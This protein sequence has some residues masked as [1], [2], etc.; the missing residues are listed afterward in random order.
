MTLITHLDH[1]VAGYPVFEEDQILT[2]NHL[3]RL[4][5][6][7]EYQTRLTRAKLLGV[8]IVHGLRASLAGEN[9]ETIILS[10][11]CGITTDGD[12]VL[13]NERLTFGAYTVHDVSADNYAPF[14]SRDRPIEAWRLV[15]D[16]ERERGAEPLSLFTTRTGQA[17]AELVAVLFLENIHEGPSL[18]SGTDCDTRGKIASSHLRVLLLHQREIDRFHAAAPAGLFANPGEMEIA[19]PA[20][21]PNLTA[22]NDLAQVYRKAA[23][24]IRSALV[25]KLQALTSAD[26]LVEN[27]LFQGLFKTNPGADWAENLARLNRIWSKADN[28]IQYYYD[29][30]K[31]LAETYNTIAALLFHH[32]DLPAPDLRTFPKHLVLG[33]ISPD[34]PAHEHRTPF[35][36]SPINSLS[37][38]RLEQ[39][40][41]LIRKLDTLIRTFEVREVETGL[42]AITP[43]L[44]EDA[45]LEDRAIP[46]Y[47]AVNADNPIHLAW[48]QRRTQQG[49]ASRTPGYRSGEYRARG[50]PR[51]PLAFSLSRFP[52]FRIEGYLGRRAR[53]VVKEIND[54]ITA[55]N[56]P[57]SVHQVVITSD[58]A[59]VTEEIAEL[60]LRHRHLHRLHQLIR[61]DLASQL[62]ATTQY[63]Q[64]LRERFEEGVRLKRIAYPPMTAEEH[65]ARRHETLIGKIKQVLNKLEGG[66]ERYVEDHSWK[67]DLIEAAKAAGEYRRHLGDFMRMEGPT[68]LDSLVE[69]AHVRWLEWLDQLID[70]CREQD[71]KRL[72]LTTFVADHP[73]AEHFGGVVRGG[74]FV[75]LTDESGIAV[76]D[77]MLP[78]IENERSDYEIDWPDLGSAENP[79]RHPPAADPITPVPT[80][81]RDIFNTTPPDRGR[82]QTPGPPPVPSSSEPAPPAD[83]SSPEPPPRTRRSIFPRQ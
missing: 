57:F 80:E 64:S 45:P 74:T 51:D 61:Q 16:A 46:S 47:Y 22:V 21:G 66:Y 18:C 75:V 78:Y 79:L 67:A 53:V 48:N 1:P 3:N 71:R 37:A 52:F 11:G 30:L 32:Q 31:D 60:R 27:P 25:E 63:S 23:N 35:Y 58:P 29:F 68:P 62:Q 54:L 7:G 59:K 28:G 73:G 55:N 44:F 34:S 8:G 15:A 17:L 2:H 13:V 42:V 26:P 50:A 72:F 82:S 83:P 4:S 19:R 38:A 43:T 77:L 70:R 24:A 36:P 5:L 10:E 6:H 49:A 56:L 81:S 12:L 39:A 76:G 33:H 40:R 20:I 65:Y 41:F 69:S 14:Q 9:R